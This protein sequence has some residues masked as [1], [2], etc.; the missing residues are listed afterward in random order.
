MCHPGYRAPKIE[1][2]QVLCNRARL[3]NLAVKSIR[4]ACSMKHLIPAAI[5]IAVSTAPALAQTVTGATIEGNVNSFDDVDLMTLQG[6]AEYA[7]TPNFGIGGGLLTYSNEDDSGTNVT[8]RGLYYTSPDSALGLFYSRDSEEGEDFDSIGIAWGHSSAGGRFEA[9]Y[10][11]V[12][13]DSIPSGIDSGYGGLSFEFRVTQNI[14]IKAASEA[15]AITDGDD[16]FTYGTSSIGARYL[17]DQGFA[18]YAEVG[19]SRIELS[20]EISSVSTDEDFIGIG[21]EYNF[22]SVNGLLQS[23]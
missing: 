13:S 22:G 6:S 19:T 3:M 12:S 17:F 10:A 9:Y 23:C 5:L 2:L 15:Y 7:I 1:I 16:T 18:I 21:A 14:Y 11:S 20:D 4:Q 8:L